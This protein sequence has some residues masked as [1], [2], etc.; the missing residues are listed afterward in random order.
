MR[1]RDAKGYLLWRMVVGG[2]RLERGITTITN[3]ESRRSVMIASLALIV[4][5]G[6]DPP[7][8]FTVQLVDAPVSKSHAVALYE[9]SAS[10]S[11]FAVHGAASAEPRTSRM[12]AQ[13]S[14]EIAEPDTA[15]AIPSTEKPPKRTQSPPVLFRFTVCSPASNGSSH[16][17]FGFEPAANSPFFNSAPSSSATSVVPPPD[18]PAIFTR[19]TP[20]DGAL[21]WNVACA[22]PMSGCEAPWKKLENW[23]I[24]SGEASSGRLKSVP[25]YL[26]QPTPGA[27]FRIPPVAVSI[28]IRLGVS[29]VCSARPLA[30]MMA[31]PRL[32]SSYIPGRIARSQSQYSALP[33]LPAN[34]PDQIASRSIRCS[35]SPPSASFGPP[36]SPQK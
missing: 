6:I 12:R 33:W 2:W 25:E 27:N 22:A 11:P 21:K 8:T 32:N 16:V 31:E 36:T 3:H 13:W 19:N 4:C 30:E 10:V 15:G 23:P 7:I 20:A 35:A 18:T 9:P 14:F 34:T 5:F 29:P 26:P 17:S 28:F 24:A 1:Q